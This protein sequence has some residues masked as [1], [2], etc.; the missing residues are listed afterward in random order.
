MGLAAKCLGLCQPESENWDPRIK[1]G[2]S[3]VPPSGK[4]R[5]SELHVHLAEPQSP[6]V[7]S[8]VAPGVSVKV[9]FWTRLIF[10]SVDLE[11]SRFSSITWVGLIQSG[12]GLH[13]R[14][15]WTSPG[16]KEFSQ[17]TTC[18]CKRQLS[19][20]SPVC[21]STLQIW[22]LPSLFTVNLSLYV[23][24]AIYLPI[25]PFCFSGETQYKQRARESLLTVKGKWQVWIS[26]NSPRNRRFSLGNLHSRV[27]SSGFRVQIFPGSSKPRN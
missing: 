7:W 20:E 25:C 21:W 19:P 17:R 12:E 3:N 23:Y 9:F 22:H 4:R 5:D 27:V 8:H 18:G 15:S 6:G 10:K 2:S 24:L 14:R 26:L 16:K 13:L 11:K 1:P